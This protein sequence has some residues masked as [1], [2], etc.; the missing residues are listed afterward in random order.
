MKYSELMA[1]FKLTTEN[2]ITSIM[3]NRFK[4]FE[5]FESNGDNSKRRSLK[6]AAN[7]AIEAELTAFVA[8]M[9]NRDGLLSDDL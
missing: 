1:D 9:N 5:A 4:I 8:G 3:K 7:P 6:G 2:T